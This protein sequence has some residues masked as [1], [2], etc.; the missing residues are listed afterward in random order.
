[1]AVYM[2]NLPFTHYENNYVLDH[3]KGLK[4]TYYPPGSKPLSRHL[5]DECYGD[6]KKKVDLRLRTARW[7]DFYTDESN[8]IRKERVIN[9]I[10]HALRGCG[11]YGGAFYLYSEINGSKTMDADT[12]LAYV[13]RQAMIALDGPGLGPHS[14]HTR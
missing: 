6:V 5:L 3:I 1:M 11:T 8:N 2:C 9:F 4:P 7:L 12:Q 14:H 13:I 10:V